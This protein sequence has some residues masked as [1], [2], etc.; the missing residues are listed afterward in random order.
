MPRPFRLFEPELRLRGRVWY[1]YWY[2]RSARQ[3]CRKSLRTTDRAAAEER[4]Q[5]FEIGA[6]YVPNSST[7]PRWKRA[8]TKMR[9]R[10]ATNALQKNRF[11][12]ITKEDILRILVEQKYVCAVT[13]MRF[14]LDE[15]HRNPFA[16]SLDQIVPG[17]GYM[18]VNV[19]VVTVIA[20]TAMNMWGEGPLRRMIREST[21]R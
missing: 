12:D 15:K 14:D 7:D 20:N 9:R 17:E 11:C 2:D 5:D 19:R 16:P 21:L 6:P 18:A 3:T 8:I 1:A 13:G 4:I 10:A